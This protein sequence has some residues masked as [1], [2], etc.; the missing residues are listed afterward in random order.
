MQ[1]WSKI[2][3]AAT[4]AGV[5]RRTMEDW[6]KQGLKCCRLPSGTRLVKYEWVDQFLEQYSE[7]PA[8]RVDQIVDR[9]LGGMKK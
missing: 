3:G 8:N 9:M 4:Y 2:K 7:D 5:S 6:L 1:G